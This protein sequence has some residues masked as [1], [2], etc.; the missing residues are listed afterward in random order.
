[1]AVGFCAVVSDGGEGA[2]VIAAAYRK[3]WSGL[4]AV[5]IDEIEVPGFFALVAHR[6][7]V[8]LL[9]EDDRYIAVLAG[10]VYGENPEGP[11]PAA[12]ELLEAFRSR[13]EA[14][15]QGLNGVC[16]AVVYDKAK[17]RLAAATDRAGNARAYWWE[18]GGRFVLGSQYTPLLR[19]GAA[20]A[21]IAEES[22]VEY[23]C[24]GCNLEDRTLYRDIR[25]LNGRHILRRAGNRT[26]V[27]KYWDYRLV[28]GPAETSLEDYARRYFD[29]LCRSLRRRVAGTVTLPITGGMDARLLACAASRIAGPNQ[30]ETYTMGANWNFDV[31]DGRRIARTLGF[32]HQTL[33]IDPAY[34]RNRIAEG[35]ERTDAAI[36][37]HTAWRMTADEYLAQRLG[38]PMLSGCWGESIRVHRERTDIDFAWPLDRLFEFHKKNHHEWM[39]MAEDEL[40]RLLRPEV[41]QQVDGFV[42]STL[43]RLFIGAPADHPRHKSEYMSITQW[44]PRRYGR[45][46]ADYFTD[47][48]P[49]ALAFNDTET[50]DFCHAMPI[51]IRMNNALNRWIFTNL[52][53]RIAAIPYASTALPIHAGPAAKLYH[54]AKGFVHYKALPKLT[55]GRIGTRNRGAYVHYRKWLREHNAAFVRDALH[56]LGPLEALVDPDGLRQSAEEVLD[57]RS[58]DFGKVYNVA[59]LSVYLGQLHNP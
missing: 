23:L 17:R 59:A 2:G 16:A 32:P 21:A 52:F 27:E 30:I 7:D 37:G 36:I 40:P 34:F 42:D 24:C 20:S 9:A 22:L 19:S 10:R 18:G 4:R 46:I 13:G 5:R 11:H 44:W 35:V 33:P 15:L 51:V 41:F 25:Y 57:G 38:R 8:P 43:R 56:D 45:M 6:Q 55:G 47:S 12:A 54:R 1:M 31:R 26:A 48:C 29:L 3:H 50:L 58:A 28:D 53:P 39:F 49:V 14:A